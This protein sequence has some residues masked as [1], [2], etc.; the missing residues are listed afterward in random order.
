MVELR[1]GRD[2]LLHL[3]F[4]VRI[5]NVTE[6]MFNELVDEDTKA[7]WL[8]GVMIVHSPAAPRHNRHAGLLRGLLHIFGDETSLGEVFG[9][10]DLVHLAICRKFAPDAFFLLQEHIPVPLPK[11]EFDLIPDW[12]AEVLSPSTR[13]YDLNE[14]RP[15]YRQAGVREIWFVDPD[16]EQVIVDRRRGK[17]YVASVASAGR[18]EST[19]IPGFWIEAKW[20]W[21]EPAPKVLQ[22]LNRILKS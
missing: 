11:E 3:P 4:T 21:A 2:T 20:L 14:K 8:D 16:R 6:E 22:C 13:A 12:I 19:A 5:P 18:I 7:E 17:R 10:D 9:P 1:L 15:A